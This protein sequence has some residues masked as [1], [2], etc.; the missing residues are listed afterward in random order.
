MAQIHVIPIGRANGCLS[1]FCTYPPKSADTHR[2][3]S[4]AA[5]SASPIHCRVEINPP[6]N[7]MKPT[8]AHPRRKPATYP[9]RSGYSRWCSH[10][11]LLASGRAFRGARRRTDTGQDSGRG[12]GLVSR[13]ERPARLAR[14][15]LCASLRRSELRPDRE[16]GVALPL[17]WLAL[18]RRGA[19]PE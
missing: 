8:D 13:P 5:V 12:A 14:P 6:T 16:W 9:H 4:G 3:F 7:A 11:L 2:R 17:S 15:L 18:R 10:A 19:L 1:R